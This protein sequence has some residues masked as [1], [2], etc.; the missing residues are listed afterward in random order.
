MTQQDN[1]K[2][3]FVSLIP[4]LMGGEGHIIPYHEAVCQAVQTLGWEHQALIPAISS[5]TPK[6]DHLPDH[7]QPCLLPTDLEAE[8]SAIA[9]LGRLTEA[10]KLGISIA[11]Y[12]QQP[13]QD[14]DRPT[15]IFLERF[16]HL[17]LFSLAIALWLMPCQHLQVWLLYRRDVHQDKT[18]PFYKFLHFLIKQRL[19]SQQLQFLTDSEPL[20]TALCQYFQV[21]MTVMPIPHTDWQE[22]AAEKQE[23]VTDKILCWWPGSPRPEKGWEM[24]KRLSQAS[25]HDGDKICHKICLVAAE[26]AELQTSHHSQ[27]SILI[28]TI[29]DRLS[30]EQY[31]HWLALSQVIL[32][33]Y[34]AE[35]YRERTSGIFTEA[36]IAG[37]I[38]LVTSANWMAKAL[39]KY[40]LEALI[41]TGE[42]PQEIVN[43]IWEVANNSGIQAKI[44]TM[45]ADFQAF[46][47]PENYAQTLKAIFDSTKV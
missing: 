13:G 15:I 32:L 24:I 17:Q 26:S 31:N 44:L 23:E 7:W 16:I 11:Q 22:E 30:R 4:N 37:K 14:R 41:L 33:P 10:I 47:N 43:Q 8:G 21:P 18:R 3:R 29:P 34:D 28:K 35:A 1:G 40:H 25:I 45:Q 27:S 38:P 6:I 9:K 39:Q 36:I 5:Q 42:S 12:F 20:Q 19:P 2:P 46:H